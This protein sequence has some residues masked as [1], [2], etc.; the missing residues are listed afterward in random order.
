[1]LLYI[2][3]PHYLREILYFF[4]KYSCFTFKENMIQC[5]IILLIY[6]VVHKVYKTD[7][8]LTNYNIKMIKQSII[9]VH[10]YSA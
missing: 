4:S 9:V 7:S 2:S 10:S 6:T 1:M 5:S 8:T 3:T